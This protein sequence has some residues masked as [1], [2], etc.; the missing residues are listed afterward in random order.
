[1][2]ANRE[3]HSHIYNKKYSEQ[4]MIFEISDKERQRLDEL[5]FYLEK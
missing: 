3:Y 5:G 4:D 2:Q 1:M